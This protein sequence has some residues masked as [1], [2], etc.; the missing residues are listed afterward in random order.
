MER[1]EIE[2]GGTYTCRIGRNQVVVR[3]VAARPD[4]GWT[5]ETEAGRRMAVLDPRRFLAYRATTDRL[6]PNLTEDENRTAE[7][8]AEH[9]AIRAEADAEAAS[10]LPPEEAPAGPDTPATTTP[11]DQ[12]AAGA[13]NAPTGRRMGLV[14]AAIQLMQEAGR[15]MR[16]M[17][18]VKA[19]RDRGLWAPTRGGK[20]PERTLY[21]AIEREIETKG[22]DSR[23]SKIERGLFAL[24]AP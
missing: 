14:A 9:D 22:A 13:P 23:F 3:V 20:T 18:M 17:E 24:R 16:C 11:P 15:P 6:D 1:D 21:A 10:A 5:V 7:E 4:I 12:E 8:E 19:A 2:V